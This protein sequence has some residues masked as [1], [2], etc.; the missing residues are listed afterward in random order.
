MGM[1]SNEMSKHF[2]MSFKIVLLSGRATFV[3]I[4]LNLPDGERKQRKQWGSE[5]SD[6]LL[7]LRKIVLS[8]VCVSIIRHHVCVAADICK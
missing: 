7:S 5:L 1:D 4:F 8:G 6:C 3:I 2:F